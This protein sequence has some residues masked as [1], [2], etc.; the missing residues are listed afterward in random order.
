LNSARMASL[1]ADCL[2]LFMP[3]SYHSAYKHRRNRANSGYGYRAKNIC[4]KLGIRS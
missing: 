4:S 2:C 3:Y 1:S